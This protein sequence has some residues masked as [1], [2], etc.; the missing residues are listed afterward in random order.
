[1]VASIYGDIM[2]QECIPV[3]CVLTAAVAATR[4]QYQGVYDATSRLVP[5]SFWGVAASFPPPP[6][7]SRQTRC[8]TFY[9]SLRSVISLCFL[10]LAYIC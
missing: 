2:K 1:M 9:L 8:K 3:G 7:R 10:C 4:C 5:C 6:P